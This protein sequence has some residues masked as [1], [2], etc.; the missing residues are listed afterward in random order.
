M[1]LGVRAA[2][3]AVV[4][5]AAVWAGLATRGRDR[6]PPPPA[7]VERGPHLF[8]SGKYGKVWRVD[9]AGGVLHTDV[10]ELQPGDPPYHLLARGDALVG[11]GRNTYLLDPALRDEPEELAR[12]SLF[13]LPSA[14]RDRVWIANE[15]DDPDSPGLIATV[16]EVAIDGDVT[17]EEVRP[18]Q[19]AWPEAAV[20]AGIVLAPGGRRIVWD[21]ETDRV[22]FRFPGPRGD[23][24][25]THGN[26]VAWCALRCVEL[27]VTEVM[28]G[29]DKVIRPPPGFRGFKAWDG[30]FS[31]DGRTIAL[32]VWPAG[33][34][35]QVHLALI[36][37]AASS[38]TPVAGTATD[39]LFNFVAWSA[40]G[41]HVFFTGADGESR[42]IFVYETATE[43]ARVVPAEVGEFYGA[44]AI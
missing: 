2:L 15:D 42:T 38:A 30:A 27:H 34:R 29:A 21:P 1:K 24:G 23:L 22:V 8:L 17:V 20:E 3:A 37:V 35:K 26:L 44:T 32:P 18:P 25:P 11:Y 12:G 40:T 16:R 36:D 10:R 4:A 5:A 6:P 43:T 33:S 14:H 19:G 31:P 41:S 9:P 39:E 7:Q 28:S 13:F